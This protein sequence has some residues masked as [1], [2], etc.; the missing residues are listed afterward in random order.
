MAEGNEK[1]VEQAKRYKLLKPLNYKGKFID[2]QKDV[3]AEVELYLDQVE[4]LKK[5]AII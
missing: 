5:L 4:P 1:V 3:G 2:P